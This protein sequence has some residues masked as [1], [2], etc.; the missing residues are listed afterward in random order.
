MAGDIAPP[1]LPQLFITAET[2]PAQ[3][4][5]ISS[6]TAQETPTVSSNPKNARQVYHTLWTGFVV[7]VPG[8]ILAAARRNP[9][10]ATPCRA[11]FKLPERSDQ[12]SGIHSP[13]RSAGVPPS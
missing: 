10:M 8:R 2:E 1:I 13:K 5:P 4:P 6:V 3:S 12:I 9:N 11:S 7:N